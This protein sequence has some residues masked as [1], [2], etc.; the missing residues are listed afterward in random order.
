MADPPCRYASISSRQ[1]RLLRRQWNSSDHAGF[2]TAK[3]WMPIPDDY[4]TWNVAN[5]VNDPNSVL[6]FWKEVLALRKQCED[7]LVGIDITSLYVPISDSQVY[8]SFEILSPEDERMFAYVRAGS[9][10]ILLNFSADPVDYRLP[11]DVTLSSCELTL[12]TGSRPVE[13]VNRLIKLEA[14][15]GAMFRIK[16]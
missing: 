4:K 11:I 14:F 16:R 10:L 15:E 2:T 8:G 5:Q 7:D 9:I 3:P 6:G 12:S 1:V 13:L